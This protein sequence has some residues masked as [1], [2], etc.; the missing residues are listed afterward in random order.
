MT[1]MLLTGDALTCLRT[2]PDT[3]V[4]ICLTSP[5]YYALRDYGVQGQ[6]GREDTPEAYVQRLVDVFAEVRRVLKPDGTLWLNI[7]D[8]Y[9]GSGQSAGT[10][11]P[12]KKQYG[13][14][15]TRHMLEDGFTSK[16]LH[17]Q[18]YKPKD[19]VGIPW[20]L[21]FALR[22]AG[23]YLRQDI[24]WHKPN[25]MPEPVKDRCTKSYEHVFLL[26][27]S[28]HYY[29]API[30][31]PC[32]ASSLQD[33]RRR[34]TLNNKG[35][36]QASFEGIR[37]DLCRSRTDYYVADGQRNIRDVWSINTKPYRGA[38]FATF[39]EELAR[40]CI[41]AGCPAGG[42]VLDPFMGAGTT[43]VVALQ[44]QRH[45]IGV[46]LN[47]AYVA[48]TEKRISAEPP[49]REEETHEEQT[50]LALGSK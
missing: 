30:R 12:S 7:A 44:E 21:A 17:L 39:P 33:F 49:R 1:D 37:P 31:E 41:L 16:L 43:A 32:S 35:G 18:G 28:Q 14:R 15:G 20:M 48:L 19:M 11:H 24:I 6:I 13:N 27:K 10:K 36:G 50:I 25:T 9:A 29:F 8:S 38:H 2:L 34:K 26:S 45:Y 5:P 23:W 42:I 22:S 3:S 47:P 4:D 40:R 46:E